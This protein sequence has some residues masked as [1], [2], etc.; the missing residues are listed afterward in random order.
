MFHYASG[1][2]IHFGGQ[3]VKGQGHEAQNSADVGFTIIFLH[4]S[5]CWLVLVQLIRAIG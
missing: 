2:P 3:K 1:K 4:S 5:D